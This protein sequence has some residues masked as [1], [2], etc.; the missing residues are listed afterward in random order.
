MIGFEFDLHFHVIFSQGG[1]HGNN[2]GDDRRACY[3]DSRELAFTA[4]FFQRSLQGFAY[5]FNILNIFFDHSIGR[6]GFHGKTFDAVTPVGFGEFHQLDG[7]GADVD[8]QNSGLIAF[9]LKHVAT[10]IIYS[11][12]IGSY[13]RIV[14]ICIKY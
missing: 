1:G 4:G 9:Q 3:S 12:S 13:S 11:L 10:S 2:F 5:G 8:S 6:Q 7:C 14:R